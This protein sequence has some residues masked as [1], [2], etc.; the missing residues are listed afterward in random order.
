MLIKYYGE[1]GKIIFFQKEE[2]NKIIDINKSNQV[3]YIK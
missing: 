1:H 3:V 2:K